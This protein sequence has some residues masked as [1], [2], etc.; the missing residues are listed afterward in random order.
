MNERNLEDISN[1][2]F[3]VIL[4]TFKKTMLENT[5]SRIRFIFGPVIHIIYVVISLTIW[6][7]KKGNIDTNSQKDYN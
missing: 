1:W 7:K 3:L 2:I 5:K 4:K 6:E